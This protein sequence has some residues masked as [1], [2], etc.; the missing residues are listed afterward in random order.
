MVVLRGLS[1]S[2]AATWVCLLQAVSSL[3]TCGEFPLTLAAAIESGPVPNVALLQVA[4]RLQTKSLA[5]S[6]SLGWEL[7]AVCTFFVVGVPVAMI[8]VAWLL[9]GAGPETPVPASSTV[10]TPPVLI[11]VVTACVVIGAMVNLTDILNSATDMSVSLTFSGYLIG[12]Y[13]IGAYLGL[14]LF[15]RLEVEQLRTACLVHASCILV[16]NA[17]Y[18]FAQCAGLVWLEVV[19]R[20]LVGMGFGTMYNAI[21]AMSHFAKGPGSTFYFVLFQLFGGAGITAG[22]A[23]ASLCDDIAMWTGASDDI[24]LYVV[25]TCWGGIFFVSLLIF[26]PRRWEEVEALAQ[27]E[28]IA[29]TEAISEEISEETPHAEHGTAL[30]LIIMSVSFFRNMQRLLWESGAMVVFVYIY[31]W[32]STFGGYMIGAVGVA[33]VVSQLLFSACISGAC[34]DSKAMR[35]MDITALCGVVL[36]FAIGH[37]QD[38]EVW[39]WT[40]MLGSIISYCSNMIWGGIVRSFCVKRAV[41]GTLSDSTNLLVADQVAVVTGILVGCVFARLVLNLVLTQN[42]LAC[43]MLFISAMQFMCSLLVL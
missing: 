24:L 16:G 1:V 43:C 7:L 31:G 39:E 2:L 11:L 8:I 27:V 36:L 14:F 3:E 28:V 13:C 5:N 30:V 12:T 15:F 41:P 38:A 17:F 10:K 34:D 9:G 26:F 29:P 6:V 33:S 25:M 20:I 35:C 18:A 32:S 42:S 21:L 40:F 22:T 23:L 4:G 37:H 19:G